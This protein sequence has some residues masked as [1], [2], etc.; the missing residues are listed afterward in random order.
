MAG[1]AFC[2]HAR[3]STDFVVGAALSQGE[4]QV[5]CRRNAFARSGLDISALQLYWIMYAAGLTKDMKTKDMKDRK[6]NRKAASQ[7]EDGKLEARP[8]EPRVHQFLEA[9]YRSRW[10]A[11]FT[12]AGL[13]RRLYVFAPPCQCKKLSLS[14]RRLCAAVYEPAAKTYD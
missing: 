1:A 11:C 5:S 8:Y 3:S 7:R 4:V 6:Q 12:A 10:Q 14:L 2:S 9:F 13:S